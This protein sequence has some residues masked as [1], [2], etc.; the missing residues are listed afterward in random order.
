MLFTYFAASLLLAVV[1]NGLGCLAVVEEPVDI[2]ETLDDSH[3]SVLH[4]AVVVI[5]IIG[6][7][8]VVAAL[9]IVHPFAF[10]FASAS[11]S[12]SRAFAAAAVAVVLAAALAAAL[13]VPAVA[14]AAVPAVAAHAPALGVAL[15]AHSE[16]FSRRR[17]ACVVNC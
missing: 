2:G 8:V 4:I 1:V 10:A 12:A 16:S 15:L 13:A 7:L 3:L 17:Q 11:A 6:V 5:E 9:N 14:A